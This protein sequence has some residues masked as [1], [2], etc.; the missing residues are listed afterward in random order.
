MAATSVI[1]G[2][3]GDD[4]LNASQAQADLRR[5][6][7]VDTRFVDTVFVD[8]LRESPLIALLT[9]EQ[10]CPHV[11]S[12]DCPHVSSPRLAL[13]MGRV[14]VLTIQLSRLIPSSCV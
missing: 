4:K 5:Q 7:F 6:I 9:C 1:D 14:M 13:S 2:S 10:P 11:S 8:I 12:P 3:S